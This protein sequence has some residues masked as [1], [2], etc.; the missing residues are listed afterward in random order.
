MT[1]SFGDR[2]P[3]NSRERRIGR[4]HLLYC[5]RL[6]RMISGK[7]ET[8][9]IKIRDTK[10]CFYLYEVPPSRVAEHVIGPRILRS[11][12]EHLDDENWDLVDNGGIESWFTQ[13]LLET[14]APPNPSLSETTARTA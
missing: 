9:Q 5:P 8:V 12:L 1:G 2:C 11:Y 7:S 4:A 13:D 10:E 14:C 6:R 3:L